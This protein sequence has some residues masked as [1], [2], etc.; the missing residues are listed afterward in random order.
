MAFN[1]DFMTIAVVCTA[2]NL[3]VN[4][5]F[6]TVFWRRLQ[7]QEVCFWCLALFINLV[8]TLLL[9]KVNRHPDA[10][11]GLVGGALQASYMGF[12]LLGFQSFFK[13]PLEWSY[14]LVVP[15]IYC[16]SMAPFVGTEIGLKIGSVEIFAALA[17]GAML[18]SREIIFQHRAEG[19]SSAP[20]AVTV[21]C[22][23]ALLQGVCVILGLLFPVLRTETGIQSDWVGWAMLVIVLHK[24][25]CALVIVVLYSDRIE[26]Q[27]RVLAN[28]DMLTGI[29]NRRSFVSQV[30]ALLRNPPQ[31]MMLAIIDLDHFKRVNDTYG[32]LAGDRVLQA[33]A[34]HVA[35]QLTPAT[36]F[37]RLGGEEFALFAPVIQPQQ[38]LDFLERLRES[39]SQLQLDF[40]ESVIEIRISIGVSFSSMS[41]NDL[42]AM[43]VAADI[44]LYTAKRDGRNRVCEFHPSQRLSQ[45]FDGS[46]KVLLVNRKLA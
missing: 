7:S 27:L 21:Y 32:H 10:V 11:F 28:T 43:M 35:S 25:M 6:W 17:L 41:G 30:D 19:L 23:F 12:M 5:G 13:R 2:V 3:V 29:P 44:A 1:P 14:T 33:F 24:G 39:V 15:F 20:L 34:S 38:S 9:L 36:R 37:G 18:I 26:N 8:G 4:V 22:S 40:D 45:F 46:E 31:N 42:D 16:V